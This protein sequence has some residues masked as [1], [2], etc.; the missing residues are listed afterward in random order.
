M[1]IARIIVG[2]YSMNLFAQ[3]IEIRVKILNATHLL[4]SNIR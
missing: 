2:I 1:I 3:E 4:I